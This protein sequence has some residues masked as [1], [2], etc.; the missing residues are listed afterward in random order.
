LYNV[1]WRD[2]RRK[3]IVNNVDRVYKGT[4]TTWPIQKQTLTTA[5]TGKSTRHKWHLE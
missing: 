5:Q 2:V 3:N 4:M 1:N